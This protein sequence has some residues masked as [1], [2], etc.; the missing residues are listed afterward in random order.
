M[1]ELQFYKKPV[2]LDTNLHSNLKLKVPL[3][4]LH[5]AADTASVPAV[6][7]EFVELCKTYPIVFIQAAEGTGFPVVVLGTDSNLFVT[8][9]GHWD[10]PYIPAFVRR[11]PFAPAEISDDGRVSIC[12]DEECPGLNETEGEPLFDSEGKP[13]QMLA[14]AIDFMTQFH[15]GMVRTDEFFKILKQAD[16]LVERNS[17]LS[18]VNGIRATLRGFMVVDE[19][20]FD[21]ITPEQLTM[22]RDKGFLPWIYLH[23]ASLSNLGGIA[24]RLALR[25]MAQTPAT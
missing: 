19:E 21:A 20:K 17:E 13:T 8:T 22:L 1:A 9:E 2:M 6:G 11:Y 7:M 10:A 23:L 24:N 14:T 3:P 4:N 16:L 18:T 25:Q 12:I 15:H 5:F